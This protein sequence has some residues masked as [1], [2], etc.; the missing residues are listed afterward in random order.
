MRN[1]I[2]LLSSLSVL[3]ASLS[4]CNFVD[5][6]QTFINE[7][8]EAY[9]K[10]L[11]SNPNGDTHIYYYDGEST[12]GVAFNNVDDYSYL[13]L[14]S[15]STLK[16]SNDKSYIFD[17]GNLPIK[18]NTD[19]GNLSINIPNYM[20]NGSISISKIL[21][22]P[23]FTLLNS[24]GDGT[25]TKYSG[26]D[27]D[28]NI[29]EA[30]DASKYDSNFFYLE[31]FKYSIN[32]ISFDY[33]GK[34]VTILRRDIIE[35]LASALKEASLPSYLDFSSTILS[36]YKTIN[37]I[38][39]DKDM[40]SI[41]TIKGEVNGKEVVVGPMSMTSI[42]G[43]EDENGNKVTFLNDVNTLIIEDGV[44]EI[45]LFAF[46]GASGI[47]EIYL[48]STL[49]E[50]SISG[51]SNLN[52]DT[53]YI[54]KTDKIIT[55]LNLGEAT[56]DNNGTSISFTG[57]LGNSNVN[58]SLLFEGYD[59]INLS[60]FPYSNLNKNTD[61]IYPKIK[62]AENKEAVGYTS[63]ADA[64][65]K[66][67]TISLQF[68][69]DL[70]TNKVVETGE[71]TSLTS[72][73]IF[74]DQDRENVFSTSQAYKS[75]DSNEYNV[76]EANYAS[77]LKLSND[78]TLDNS[79]LIIGAYIG[80]NGQIN[81]EINGKYGAIDLNGHKLT[82]K[83]NS[84]IYGYGL[85]FDSSSSN[86]GLIEVED[87]S[88]LVT[89]MNLEGYFSKDS[90]K[91]K[92]N[93]DVNPFQTYRFNDLRCNVNVKK[94]GKLTAEI[95]YFDSPN[96]NV[97]NLIIG[98]G[99]LVSPSDENTISYLFEDGVS[100][101]KSEGE[102]SLNSIDI[103]K[104]DSSDSFSF[105]LANKYICFSLNK[106]VIN[107]KDSYL[108]PD[109]I[110]NVNELTL[111]GGLTVLNKFSLN[112]SDAYYID[113]EYEN[114]AKLIINSSISF[115]SGAYIVGNVYSTNT[116]IQQSLASSFK[117]Q[118][119]VQFG[120]LSKNSKEFIWISSFNVNLKLIN[121][122]LET[123]Y[124]DNGTFLEVD[125]TNKYGNLKY[126]NANT[127]TKLAS[128]TSNSNWTIYLDD[129]SNVDTNIVYTD[130]PSEYVS[131][132]NNYLL[133]NGKWTNSITPDENYVYTFD[134][135]QY[136]KYDNA[137]LQG[138]YISSN[139]TFV[140]SK[141]NIYAR[142]NST[143]YKCSSKE[144]NRIL[145]PNDIDNP[146]FVFC[147]SDG[148]YVFGNYTYD[149]ENHALISSENGNN[150][151][152]LGNSTSPTS[153]NSSNS[154]SDKTDGKSYI[155]LEEEGWVKASVSSDGEA[156]YNSESYF[157]FGENRWEK[158]I[159]F[160]GSLHTEFKFI[161]FTSGFTYKGNSYTYGLIEEKQGASRFNNEIHYINVDDTYSKVTLKQEDYSEI[162]SKIE[163]NL[164]DDYK[165]IVTE[166][167]EIILYRHLVD[168]DGNKYLYYKDSDGNITRKQFEFAS[169]FTPFEAGGNNILTKFKFFTYR[170]RFVG[171]SSD[172]EIFMSLDCV[173]SGSIDKNSEKPEYLALAIFQD[174]SI[175]SELVSNL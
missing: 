112:S 68:M 5:P 154:I 134:N 118:N 175:V 37:N 79:S 167:D 104:N 107:L 163:E 117:Y 149:L 90:Y 43:K 15:F 49:E 71:L 94:G 69:F 173:G 130:Y 17:L 82:L 56:I 44:K 162:W 57:A 19:N 52:L 100:T 101:F 109:S 8:K 136:I 26:I 150:L 76:D 166:Y 47:K 165:Y 127:E 2:V 143:Y 74:V 171:E 160:S 50:V 58:E 133:I 106:A 23:P 11:E 148:K 46:D 81:G 128:Y 93:N 54:P 67:D 113:Y 7:A 10:Y 24:S 144:A 25:Y 121:N 138:S 131:G 3:L 120:G 116:N 102:V 86:S 84:T 91:S 105:P 157:F 139:N 41:L 75:N 62:I 9:Q 142:V 85:I 4:S 66:N 31:D 38:A 114:D 140:D 126:L 98:E 32:E 125:T 155:Y 63:L 97:S 147:L 42:F 51:L 129:G 115:N 14:L 123:T 137:Y 29:I 170:V 55:F 16:F 145:I 30:T 73:T 22:T 169:D 119:K 151:I 96:N 83:N 122:T 146:T 60:N 78:L 161:R 77:C 40:P 99:G 153:V 6:T 21:E 80:Q 34:M 124:Y 92:V 95:R 39:E 159:S 103:S 156:K 87:G 13:G 53:L 108:M 152:Y 88:N 168:E 132:S 70:T 89:N 174:E 18:L 64:V 158:A 33:T 164:P 45:A 172:R 59:N 27:Q 61:S 28:G 36:N 65:S 110:F 20:E 141:N 135:I 12:R 1:K 72:K 111:N 48:P 35:Y